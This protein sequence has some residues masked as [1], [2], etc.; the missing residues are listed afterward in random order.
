M[1][2]IGAAALAQLVPDRYDDE[3]GCLVVAPF[4]DDCA[5]FRLN[6]VR[7]VN[8]SP[9][10]SGIGRHRP[11]KQNQSSP[12]LLNF[13]LLFGDLAP[14]NSKKWDAARDSGLQETGDPQIGN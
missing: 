2:F 5:G 14:V 1:T 9:D 6:D 13:H 3:R 11:A 10:P 4:R 12:A 8:A 7:I